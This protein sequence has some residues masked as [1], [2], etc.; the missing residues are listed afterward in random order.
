MVGA[1]ADR[2]V[3]V[4]V[5]SV[6][7]A[8]DR[9]DGIEDLTDGIDLEH[10]INTLEDASETL[11]THAGVD[12]LLR[13]LGVIAVAVVVELGEYVVPDLHEA[14]AVTAGLAVG[15]AA[16]ASLAAVEV[17]LGAGAAG[18]GAVLPEVVGL[19]EANDV[20]GIDADAV[21]P[22]VVCLLVVLVDG[23]PEELLGDL[24]GLGQEFPSPRNCL[25]FEVIAEGEVAQH[26]KEGAVAGGM[27]DALKVRS[28]DALLAGA[29]AGARGLLLTRE[30]F[31]HGCHT[32]V[33]QEQGFIVDRHEREGGETEMSLALKKCE[34][35]LAQIVQICTWL[36]QLE[37]VK[38]PSRS[39]ILRIS[40]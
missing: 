35:L 13:E 27:A 3:V 38:I 6:G 23:G 31:L 1:D 30:I 7:L 4:L 20:S 25:V 26:L 34:I 28:T 37:G 40:R 36:V 15:R 24:Q 21:D 16:A 2:N 33:D 17:D 9:A 11:E 12:V 8:R 22:D 19:A 5:V 39:F 32:G 29:N 18:A 14:V 10:I